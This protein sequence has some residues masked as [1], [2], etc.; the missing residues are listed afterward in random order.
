MQQIA[1]WLKEFG[2]SEYI[3]RFIENHLDDGIIRELT[4]QDLKDLGLYRLATAAKCCARSGISG[5]L[6]L[7]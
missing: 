3:D 2:M 7:P 6:R 4:D 1:D 5:A